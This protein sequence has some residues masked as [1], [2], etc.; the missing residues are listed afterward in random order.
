MQLKSYEIAWICV[1]A[2]NQAST[3][4]L[5]DCTCGAAMCSIGVEAIKIDDRLVGGGA[6]ISTFNL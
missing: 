3:K 4:I 5:L 1:W 6:Y 2:N